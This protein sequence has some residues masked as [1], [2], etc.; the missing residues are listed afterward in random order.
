MTLSHFTLD[1]VGGALSWRALLHFVTNLGPTSALM[2]ETR[3][4]GA[5]ML[6]WIDGTAVAPL[7]AD[8][9]D[10]TNY[11]RW[12]YATSCTPKGKR[13]PRKPRQVKR[14]WRKDA[15]ERKVGRDPIPIGEFDAWWDSKDKDKR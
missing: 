12:E 13:K 7:L 6:P 9:I 3:P 15:G 14:P 8:L 2:R 10:V 4:E 5:D 11:A 1:D